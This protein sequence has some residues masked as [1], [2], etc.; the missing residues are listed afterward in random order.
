MRIKMQCPDCGTWF[1][2]ELAVKEKSTG[3]AS[4]AHEETGSD[5]HK[6]DEVTGA[7]A[8]AK[9]AAHVRGARSTA[10]RAWWPSRVV[11]VL[12]VAAVVLTW[13]FV[14]NPALERTRSGTLVESTAAAPAEP[15]AEEAG[16]GSALIGEPGRESAE[17]EAPTS[18]G[19]TTPDHGEPATVSDARTILDSNDGRLEFVL[20]ATNRCWVRVSADGEVVSDV[21]LAAGERREW[22]GESY[23][24]LAAGSGEDVEVYLNGEFLG[25]AGQDSRVVEGLRISADGFVARS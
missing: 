11:P 4:A 1:T 24:E 21:T 6:R 13:F 22:S 19:Q 23:F 14:V 12:V 7:T 17:S 8:S 2:L 16:V 3:R 20:V 15:G 5:A 25:T 18:A 9:P 10:A